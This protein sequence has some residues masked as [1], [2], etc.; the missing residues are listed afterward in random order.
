MLGGSGYFLGSLVAGGPLG[1]IP[2]RPLLVGGNV[3]MALFMGLALSA[4]LGPIGTVAMLSIA[5]FAGAFGWVAIASLLT[6]ETPAGVGTTM[7][8]HG[9]LFNLGAAAGAAI[10]GLLLA[11][12]G[13][14][15]LALGLPIFGLG[16]AL[17]AG[18][19]GRRVVRERHDV[20]EG[21]TRRS[22]GTR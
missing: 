2:P 13:Y 20:S 8:L 10:G 21:S 11:L 1:R 19:P 6:V 18:W 3:V 9:S 22:L 5:T 7:T 14:D 17:L 15:A 4:I 16:S 12:L